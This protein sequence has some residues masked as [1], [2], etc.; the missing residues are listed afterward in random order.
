M[1]LKKSIEKYFSEG[2]NLFSGNFVLFV[3]VLGVGILSMIVYAILGA[4]LFF[5]CIRDFI[6]MGYNFQN[7]A[8]LP[9][10]SIA[11]Y[12]GNFIFYIVAVLTIAFLYNLAVTILHRAGLGFMNSRVVITGRTDLSEYF[13]G[14][15]RFSGRMFTMSIIRGSILLIPIIIVLFFSI[16]VA[17]G[18]GESSPVFAII[19]IFGFFGVFIFEFIAI[20]VMWMWKPALFVKDISV[21]EALAECL[22]FTIPRISTLF[23]C[24]IIWFVSTSVISGVFQAFIT[25]FN[26]LS[27]G[28]ELSVGAIAG[29]MVFMLTMGRWIIVLVMRVF[30]S[31]FY[32]KFF[33]DE[34]SP[35]VL[36]DLPRPMFA[37]P[38]YPY[39]QYPVTGPVPQ[40]YNVNRPLE[41]QAET[42]KPV[43]VQ[44]DDNPVANDDSD[45]NNTE[46]SNGGSE[47]DEQ[48]PPGFC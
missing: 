33:H 14:I 23:L 20:F 22:S 29:I 25:M 43:D 24:A 1:R 13:E 8:N 39:Q 30:F 32:Y 10:S 7:P 9:W 36:P 27:K 19:L 45:L 17:M 48:L 47:D 5:A 15:A 31:V 44:D 26:T 2:W 3:P 16:L 41:I 28:T 40:Q 37:Q 6:A 38:S 11:N 18:R 21:M 42:E 46:N 12:F 4:V 34:T 35:D